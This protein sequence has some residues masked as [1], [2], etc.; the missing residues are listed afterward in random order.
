V[1]ARTKEKKIHHALFGKQPS[2]QH[3]KPELARVEVVLVVTLVV[4]VVGVEWKVA[5]HGGQR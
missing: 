4:A 5:D 2:A 1:S 3:E